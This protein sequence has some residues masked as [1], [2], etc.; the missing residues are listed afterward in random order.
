MLDLCGMEGWQADPETLHQVRVA[1]RRVRAVLDLVEPK[2][3]PGFK[4]QMKHLRGLTRALGRTRELDVHADGIATLR[5]QHSAVPLQAAAEHLLERLERGRRKA[6]QRMQ[7][8]LEDVTLR[9]IERLL[10]PPAIPE[11]IVLAELPQAAWQRLEPWLRAVDEALPP[12]LESEDV[13]ALHELRI[14]VKRLRYTL[15]TLEPAFPEPLDRWLQDLK[16]LQ[17]ALGGHHDHALLEALLWETHAELA[18]RQRTV[19]SAGLMDLIEH[20]AAAR[21]AYFERFQTLGRAY[22]EAVLFSHL[23]QLADRPFEVNG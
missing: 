1:S 21:K 15:E 13:P 19:L 8:D 5:E 17:T 11:P 12:V 4:R 14:H 23:K 10:M 9:H 22:R 20:V 2:H 7:A 6:R 16:E 18:E 3:Y